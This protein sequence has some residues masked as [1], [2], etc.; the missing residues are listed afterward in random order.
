MPSSQPFLRTLQWMC[1]ITWIASLSQVYVNAKSKYLEGLYINFLT[2]ESWDLGVKRSDFP[3]DFAFFLCADRRI[4]RRCWK[5]AKYLGQ[6][7]PPN[8]QR[9]QDHSNMFTATDLYKRYR[10][11]VQA[12]LV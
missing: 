3:S 11:D 5:R 8:P 12:T 1:V 10:E 7:Y 6:V 4:S 9:I 2:I